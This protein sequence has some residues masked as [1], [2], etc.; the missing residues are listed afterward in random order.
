M[1][2]S[3]SK[4]KF[5]LGLN[6][7]IS[8]YRCAK[9]NNYTSCAYPSINKLINDSGFTLWLDEDISSTKKY[10]RLYESIQYVEKYCIDNNILFENYY[11]KHN[12][13]DRISTFLAK[14]LITKLAPDSLTRNEIRMLMLY[15]F[16]VISI[17]F[18][19]IYYSYFLFQLLHY[20][21]L[22]NSL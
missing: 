19:I 14:I 10:I 16:R 1:P 12:K 2:S 11:P 6:W 3:R 22:D 8:K 21:I 13:N 9:K 7:Q 5:E 17:L 20:I 15:S 4:N 18:I